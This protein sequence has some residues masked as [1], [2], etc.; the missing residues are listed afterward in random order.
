MRIV[1]RITAFFVSVLALAAQAQNIS[2]ATG[3]TGGVYYPLGGGM[4]A[5]L[6][7]YVPGLQATAEVT[8]GSALDY[9]NFAGTATRTVIGGDAT[10]DGNVNFDDV[11]V[12]SPN[13]GGTVTNG[14]AGAD[15]TGDGNVNFDD[16]LVM[17]PNF[18]SSG[19]VNT[20]ININGVAGGAGSVVAA[21]PEPASVMMIVLGSLLLGLARRR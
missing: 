14:W 8:G 10:V 17:S 4:A 7:K 11:L 15:F 13:F 20:P 12:M 1:A 9:S 6:S 18:G 3:G 2:I 5:V 16:V 21:V 19:G